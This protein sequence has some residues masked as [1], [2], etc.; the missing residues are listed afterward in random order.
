[1]L[2]MGGSILCLLVNSRRLCKK[3]SRRGY[4]FRL[5]ESSTIVVNTRNNGE[6]EMHQYIQNVHNYI[7]DLT[8][9]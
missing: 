3:S 2:V 9:R 8:K 7:I 4:A 1:M 5:S 6:G